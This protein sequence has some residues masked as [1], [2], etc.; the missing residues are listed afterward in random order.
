MQKKERK[1]KMQKRNGAEL[2]EYKILER[3]KGYECEYIM[4]GCD[5]EGKKI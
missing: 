4:P 3:G 1:E 5:C 2:N